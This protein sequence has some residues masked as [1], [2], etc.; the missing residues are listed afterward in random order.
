M[1]PGGRG[2]QLGML[3][4]VAGAVALVG[5]PAAA[6]S[7][8]FGP[9]AD[10]TRSDDT[11]QVI[12]V[13]TDAGAPIAPP[14]GVTSS[15]PAGRAALEYLRAHAGPL[16]LSGSELGITGVSSASAGRFVV[17]TQQSVSGA[18]VLGGELIVNLTADNRI[19]SVS[20]EAEPVGD[21]AAR[22]K[23]SRNRVSP[24]HFCMSLTE[25]G[26]KAPR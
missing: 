23:V 18:P 3:A 16:G 8:G 10:L 1:S 11:G 13:G 21:F 22:P 17:R 12:F 2:R 15:S 20:G 5:A 9:Y 6:A 24:D 25:A 19:L 4:L 26:P 14:A 7:G